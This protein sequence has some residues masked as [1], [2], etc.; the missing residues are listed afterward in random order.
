MAKRLFYVSASLLMLALT[1]HLGASAARA[2]IQNTLWYANHMDATVGI[3]AGRTIRWMQTGIGNTGTTGELPPV[4][5]SPEIVQF[6]VG[7]MSAGQPEALAILADGSVWKLGIGTS[8]WAMVGNLLS[9]SPT[10]T[11]QSS[12]GALKVKAR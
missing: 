8:A 1:Y 6:S 11:L 5:G 10:P 7:N 12:W 4:P 3:V 2:Q 9:G